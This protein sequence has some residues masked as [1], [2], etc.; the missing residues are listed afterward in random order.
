[1]DAMRSGIPIGLRA[2][3]GEQALGTRRRSDEGGNPTD[4]DAYLDLQRIVLHVQ[5]KP[6]HAPS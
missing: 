4:L 1:M 3:E 6:R 5:P 2:S